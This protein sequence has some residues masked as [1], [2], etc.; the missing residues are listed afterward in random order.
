MSKAMHISR[1]KRIT[2][3]FFAVLMLSDAILPT[4]A[5]ALSSGP[6]QPEVQGFTPAGTNDMVNLFSGDFSYNIPLLDV[7]GYPV[8]L[9]Y[10]AGVGV[11]QEASWVGL[12]WNLNPGV[13]E[14]NLRGLPDDFDGDRIDRTMN[15]RPNRTYGLSYSVGLQLFGTDQS[16][17]GGSLNLGASPSFNNY[18]G[19]EFTTSVGMSMQSTAANNNS[20]TCGLGLSSSS[21]QGLTVSPTIGFDRSF[22]AGQNR[23]KAGLNFG[24]SLN[25]MKGLTNASFGATLSSTK[26]VNKEVKPAGQIGPGKMALDKVATDKNMKRMAGMGSSFDLGSPTYSPQVTLPMENLSV[27]F[28]VT[29]FAAGAGAHPNMTLG[30]FYSEQHLRGHHTSKPAYG[31]LHLEDGQGNGS[32]MLDFNREKDGPFS[33]DKAGLGVAGLTNDVFAVS[34]QGVS[35]SYRAYRSEIGHVF[36]A[37]TESS[38]SSGSFGGEV[39]GGFGFHFG[40]DEVI[41]QSSSTSGDWHGGNQAGQRLRYRSLADHPD[42]EPVFFREANEA[43]VEQ[44]SALWLAFHKDQ[45]VQFTLPGPNGYDRSLGAAFNQGGTVPSTNYKKKREPRAQVFS[46]LDHRMAMDVGLI[47][48]PAGLPNNGIIPPYHMSEVTITG[49]D[50]GRYVYGRPVYNI[51]QKDVEFAVDINDSYDPNATVSG[52]PGLIQYT[53]LTDNSTGNKKGR[54][55]YYSSSITPPYAYAFLL[56]AVVSPD[57]SD[58]DAVRGPSDGDLGNYTRFSY[59]QISN[60]IEWRTP[61]VN[62]VNVARWNKGLTGDPK[63]DKAS[64]V[65]GE[66]EA[67]YLDTIVTRN[68]IAVFSTSVRQ[69]AKGVT[70][71]GTISAG[72]S[73]MQLDSISLYEKKSFLLDNSIAPIKRVHF[74]YDYSLCHNTPNSTAPGTK[75]KLTLKKVWFTYGESDRGVTTPYVFTYENNQDYS[76]ATQDRWG[77]FK[78]ENPALPNEDFPYAEQGQAN[79]DANAAAWNLESVQTPSGALITV[80][81]EADDY[82]FVQDKLAMRMFPLTTMEGGTSHF[83]LGSGLRATNKLS[84]ALPPECSVMSVGAVQ[85]SL[86]N[87]IHDLYFRV[88]VNIENGRTDYVSGYARVDTATFSI[89]GNTGSVEL[90]PEQ[91]DEGNGPNVNPIYRAGLEFMRL[92]YPRLIHA[93]T[94]GDLNDNDMVS[95]DFLYSAITSITGF[96]ENIGAFFTGPNQKLGSGTFCDSVNPSKSWI[97][98]NEPDRVKKGGGHRVKSLRIKDNW[99]LMEPGEHEKSFEYGQDYAYGD[100]TGSFGVAAYEPM[101]GADENPWRQP[102]YGSNPTRALTPDERFYQETPFGE[103]LF[104]SPSVGYSQVVVTDHYPDAIAQATQGTGRV[105]HEFYTAKDFPTRTARTAIDRQPENNNPNLLAIFGFSKVDHMH[106]TQGYVV[107]T[108]DMH[109]KPK[110]VSVFP[111]G[112]D[113]AISITSYKYA[114]RNDGSGRLSNAATTIDPQGHIGR[115]EIGRQYE[116]VADTRQFTSTSRSGGMMLNLEGLVFGPALVPVPI[117]L[118]KCSSSS[119]ILKTGVLVKKIHRFGLL[120]SVTQVNNGSRVKTEN[121]AYD[122]QT[123]DV[124]LTKL[125]NAFE[126]PIYSFNFP[127][128]WYYEGMGPAYKNIGVHTPLSLNSSGTA[129]IPNAPNLFFPGDVLALTTTSGSAT[130]EHGWVNAVGPNTIEV[131]DRHG[132]PLTGDRT[133]VVV[134]SGRRNM[135]GVDM[136]SLTL[137][138]NPLQGMESN[139]YANILNVKAQ[140]FKNTWRAECACIDSTAAAPNDWLLNRKGTWRLW[141]DRVW[142]TDRTRSVYDHNANIRRDGTYTAFAPFY[143]VLNGQWAKD[144]AGWTTAREV[145]EYNSRGQEL[146]NKDALGLYSSANF[147]YG[148]GLPIA[149]AKNARHTDIMFENFEEGTGVADCSSPWKFES[150]AP[151]AVEEGDAHTGRYGLRV[152]NTSPATITVDIASCPP[153]D[154]DLQLVMGYG[155]SSM[156]ELTALQGTAPYDFSVEMIVDNGCDGIQLQHL[157]DRSV[158]VNQNGGSMCTAIIT[159]TD[160]NGCTQSLTWSD[161]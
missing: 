22:N 48:P 96:I 9:A 36:D 41:N 65:Y 135:Q 122:A 134:R 53:P 47:A 76:M 103:S 57:Y 13:V 52:Y 11:D 100:A 23:M 10:N 79:A 40:G 85:D 63:D 61:M 136:M 161:L 68:Y 19:P 78:L 46:Y 92:H 18:D 69:D 101:S 113:Q 20:M 54:D 44:D 132:A 148:G 118:P 154:C 45:P 95:V 83:I 142:L 91:I 33:A 1:I 34:G 107:E 67:C 151:N 17:W 158:Q 106:A 138:S 15:L 145:T 146:E 81:Y 6:S 99:A 124:L 153:N 56:T 26:Q 126:D 114:Q 131:M 30:A 75:G 108:N 71:N 97:R 77:N 149:I 117:I 42:L 127:A 110:S 59:K 31:Y 21:V 62:V 86:F 64:Y 87:G 93:N 130:Y 155:Q 105:V 4:M 98:L 120:Q 43:V 8:N 104:P 28:S 125:T 27:S 115:A 159:V 37:Q 39:G 14:R 74:K 128:Y 143:Q 5:Y 55:H 147:G 16:P 12:G 102:V 25:S 66:K 121:L 89:A 82:A 72:G 133:V 140:E 94:P 51:V 150:S 111:E 156:F 73:P 29:G 137:Q 109:G 112:S 38:G 88:N 129:T 7:E 144:Q 58:V 116:F 123:G 90:I 139:V 84:F 50:G 160:A 157:S 152:S 119:T 35:G 2:A 60:P 49:K 3:A 32:A 80:K 141:K 24:L 70:E